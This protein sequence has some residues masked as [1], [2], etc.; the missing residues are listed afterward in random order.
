MSTAFLDTSRSNLTNL[1]VDGVRL[2]ASCPDCQTEIQMDLNRHLTVAD[3]RVTVPV[4]CEACGKSWFE[5]L[6]VSIFFYV[7]K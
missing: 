7:V 6:G 3:K 1:Q 4:H 2:S 5:Q